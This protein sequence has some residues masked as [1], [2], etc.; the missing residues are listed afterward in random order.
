MGG[1][2]SHCLPAGDIRGH[3]EWLFGGLLDSLTCFKVVRRAE[4]L[5]AVDETLNINAKPNKYLQRYTF[6]LINLINP[7]YFKC[8][9]TMAG[10]SQSTLQLR[11]ILKIKLAASRYNY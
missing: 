5:N 1:G 11:R 4:D 8:R 2:E 6:K 10:L 7:V 9:I 3:T